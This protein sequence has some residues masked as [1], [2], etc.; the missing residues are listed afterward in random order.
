MGSAVLPPSHQLFSFVLNSTISQCR[1]NL[2]G[3]PLAQNSRTKFMWW[4][5]SLAICV[6]LH[7]CPCSFPQTSSPLPLHVA[8]SE[9][10]VVPGA[11]CTAWCCM[12][13]L[14]CRPLTLAHVRPCQPNHSASFLSLEEVM[15]W[16]LTIC[17]AHCKASGSNRSFQG[18]N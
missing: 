10:M 5:G 2:Q 13:R 12:R 18:S 8:D 6:G 7:F 16:L 15:D 17:L 11:G 9:R 1:T 3:V 4:G 14:Y